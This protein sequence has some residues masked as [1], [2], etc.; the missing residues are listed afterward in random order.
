M[1]EYPKLKL[2]RTA[3]L[4]SDN[5]ILQRRI[6]RIFSDYPIECIEPMMHALIEYINELETNVYSDAIYINLHNAIALWQNL[7]D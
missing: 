2:I 1:D 7:D 5:D 6:E 4:V 3:T